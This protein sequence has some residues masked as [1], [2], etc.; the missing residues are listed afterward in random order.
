MVDFRSVAGNVAALVSVAVRAFVGTVSILLAAGI[1]LAGASYYFLNDHPW[2]ATIAAAVALTEALAAG[3]ILGSKRAFILAAAHGLGMLRLGRFFVRVLFEHL[4]GVSA[5]QQFGERGGWI[6]QQVERVPLAQAENCLNQVVRDLVNAHPAGV[7]VTGRFRSR[8]ESMLLS[9]VAKVTLARLREQGA[10]QGGVD[11]VKAQAELES[12]MD[13]ILIARLRRG[14][15]LW[16]VLVS[17]GLPVT[18]CAQTY[19]AI[20]LLK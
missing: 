10:E 13:D 8:I 20:A 19:I 15:N 11:L 12:T 17:L 16:T 2:Y 14:L 5:E 7:G 6:A 1:V 18:V 4:L 3:C 9:L